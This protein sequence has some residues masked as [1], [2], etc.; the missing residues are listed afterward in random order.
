MINE[1]KKHVHK[2]EQ[3]MDHRSHYMC[4]KCGGE[5]WTDH[6]IDDAY[7]EAFD[8]G[9]MR[10]YFAAMR[11]DKMPFDLAYVQK[12]YPNYKLLASELGHFPTI[13]GVKIESN[14]TKL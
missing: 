10:G 11:G 13:S 5:F 7:Q 9:T 12:F 8:H 6:Y 14:E 2:L 3:M 4:I 1:D